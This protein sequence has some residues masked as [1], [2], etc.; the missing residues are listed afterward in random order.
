M[1]IQGT[2]T[3][4]SQ[5]VV[6]IK[7][8]TEISGD[9]VEMSFNVEPNLTKTFNETLYLKNKDSSNHNII[10]IKVTDS[11]GSHFGICKVYIYE[12]FTQSGQWTLV[13]T[14]DIKSTSSE[15]SNK[16]LVTNGYYKFDFEI[17]ATTTGSDNGF[18][19]KVTY[20]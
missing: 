4:G 16:T 1:Y 19:I 11:V 10:S 14:L 8:G 9:T 5:K 17:R 20:E 18:T 13:G 12:N 6:W 2:I 15:I 3:I 7:E